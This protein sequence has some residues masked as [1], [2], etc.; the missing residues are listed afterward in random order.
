[1]EL[2]PEH[3]LKRGEGEVSAEGG[4]V[5]VEQGRKPFVANNCSRRIHGSAVVVARME[6][7]IV[8]STLQL[9]ASFENFG[10][11]IDDRCSK[12]AKKSC[13]NQSQ[14]CSRMMSGLYTAG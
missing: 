10:W 12:V 13:G 8:I 7:R 5:A 3:E 14:L 1:M 11:D 6:V 9:E 4:L 2:F